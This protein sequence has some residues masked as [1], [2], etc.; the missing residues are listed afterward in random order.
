MHSQYMCTNNLIGFLKV[1]LNSLFCISLSVNGLEFFFKKKSKLKR[2]PGKQYKRTVDSH[3][4]MGNIFSYYLYS[5]LKLSWVLL[6]E[7][8]VVLY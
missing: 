5:V 4:D 7:C 3:W 2:H 6:T 8:Q 1:C